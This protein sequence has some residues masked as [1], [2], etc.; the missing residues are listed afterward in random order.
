MPSRL[1]SGRILVPLPVKMRPSGRQPG[2][3]RSIPELGHLGSAAGRGEPVTPP[4]HR[5]P[6]RGDV[7]RE[8]PLG[9]GDQHPAGGEPDETPA[10][11]EAYEAG[12]LPSRRR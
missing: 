6:E 1:T 11:V 7:E 12:R 10:A 2:L 3:R 9:V 4:G 5:L 8:L